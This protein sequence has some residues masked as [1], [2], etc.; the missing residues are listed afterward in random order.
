VWRPGQAADKQRQGSGAVSPHIPPAGPAKACSCPRRTTLL[1]AGGGATLDLALPCRGMDV[2]RLRAG[3]WV[4]ATCGV[5]LLVSLWMPWYEGEPEGG[6]SLSAWESLAA[7]DVLLALIA[8]TAVGLLIITAAQSVPAVPMALSVFVTFAG[9]L[10]V[11]LVLLRVI[12]VPGGAEGR[13]WGLWLALACAIGIV[14]GALMAM[15]D[16]RLSPPGGHT[17]LTGRPSPPPPEIET[18]PAPSP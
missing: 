17:D 3:E 8:A 4:A 18:F 14:A 2:R 10:G 1:R 12:S 9:L 15:R 13:D 5:G 16:E 11:L 7:L 6:A